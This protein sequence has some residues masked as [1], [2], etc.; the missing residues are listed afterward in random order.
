MRK[1]GKLAELSFELSGFYIRFWRC[2]FSDRV[3]T[4]LTSIL[5]GMDG[6]K[7]NFFIFRL[8]QQTLNALV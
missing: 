5:D 7:T 3:E 1:S 2:T 8:I 4:L 6:V